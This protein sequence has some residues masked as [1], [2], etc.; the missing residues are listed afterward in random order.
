MFRVSESETKG[1]L[2]WSLLIRLIDTS[3]NR[4]LPPVLGGSQEGGN[5]SFTVT[6]S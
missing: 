5:G 6:R 3:S 4:L 1:P 2:S